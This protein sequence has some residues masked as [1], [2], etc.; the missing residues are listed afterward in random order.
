MNVF[1]C[2]FKTSLL[3]DFVT[4][5]LTSPSSTCVAK[6]GKKKKHCTKPR[7]DLV[8]ETSLS[9]LPTHT[10]THTTM[11]AQVADHS[12]GDEGYGDEA[13][14]TTTTSPTG[15]GGGEEEGGALASLV[16]GGVVVG[17]VPAI[18][19]KAMLT[20]NAGWLTFNVFLLVTFLWGA[21]SFLNR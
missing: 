1:V 6:S 10:H 18:P 8:S 7:A 9:L 21:F 17:A 4:E 14:A 15:G 2:L 20:P 16:A 11:P 12:G 5:Q 13:S 3:C 19:P